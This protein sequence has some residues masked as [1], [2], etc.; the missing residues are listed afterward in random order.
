VPTE[1]R[2]LFVQHKVG[3]GDTLYDL[4]RAYG[5]TVGAI[6]QANQM[7]RKTTIR[8][9]RV[10]KI[11]SVAAGRFASAGSPGTASEGEVVAYR[12][13]RGDTLSGIAR[14][15]NTSSRAIAAASGISVNSL[16]GIGKRLTVVSGVRSSEQA[17]RIAS[18]PTEPLP[19]GEHRTYRVRRGDSLWR[20]AQRHDTT[21]GALCALNSINRNSV[22]RPGTVLK[23]RN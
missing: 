12:V 17:R 10:L 16:L 23:I 22:L 9:G 15:Y 7:G 19:D 1:E 21:V 5:V 4:A 2:V 6:Q 18:G 8:I 3:R 20:I 13:R 14:R 11:P